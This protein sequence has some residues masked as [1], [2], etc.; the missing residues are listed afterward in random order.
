MSDEHLKRTKLLP[1]F[2]KPMPYNTM[3]MDTPPEMTALLEEGELV[4]SGQG[5]VGPTAPIRRLP[6]E[7]PVAEPDVSPLLLQTLASGEEPKQTRVHQAAS[8]PE[9]PLRTRMVMADALPAPLPAPPPPPATVCV[10]KASVS[11]ARPSHLRRRIVYGVSAVVLGVCLALAM[12]DEN[13]SESSKA[14][15]ASEVSAQDSDAGRDPTARPS[16][17]QAAEAATVAR[18]TE[19]TEAIAGAHLLAGRHTEALAAYRDLAASS[20]ATPG[21][22][23]MASVLSQKVGLDE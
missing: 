11:D 15:V 17:S 4:S 16:H 13:R 7:S 22:E 5:R 21:V 20:K 18:E 2:G 23:A 1:R 9:D 12:S 19:M 10:P 3:V 14:P 6:D 8:A